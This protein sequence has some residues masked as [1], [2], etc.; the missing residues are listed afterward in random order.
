MSGWRWLPVVF[1][2]M[3]VSLSGCDPQNIRE[4]EEGLSTE[5]DVRAR[6][7][8]PENIW[9]APQGAR[10][11]EYN[12]QPQGYQ[13]YMITIGADGKMSALRQVLAPHNFALIVPGMT[14][15]D[16]R[17]RLG[18]PMKVTQFERLRQTH[19]DWRYRDGPNASDARI[20]TVVM[21]ADLR[22]ISSGSVRD[23]ALDQGDRR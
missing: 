14:M 21:D 1:V 10:T 13:N 9:D 4:L 3:C 5:A 17:R 6:F 23:P 8:E 11:L 20:F 22:V 15:E 12:R 16:V 7:G 19:Y 2:A 18:K